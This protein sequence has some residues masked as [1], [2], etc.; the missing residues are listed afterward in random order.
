MQVVETKKVSTVNGWGF[1][2]WHGT[3]TRYDNGLIHKKGKWSTRHQ[4]TY[5][6]NVWSI[7]PDLDDEFETILDRKPNPGEVIYIY[8]FENSFRA[9]VG[10]VSEPVKLFW[11]SAAPVLYKTVEV[12][13]P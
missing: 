10:P 7:R 1:N 13:Q 2:G 6:Y 3:Y 4:G 9:R 5:S 12:G 8:E 11:A